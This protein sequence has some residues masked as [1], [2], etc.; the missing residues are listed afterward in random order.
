MG[1]LA[2]ATISGRT[3]DAHLFGVLLS[4]IT[5]STVFLVA[6]AFLAPTPAAAIT[7]TFLIG[8]SWFCTLP[9]LT[10][11]IFN[12][13]S[14]APTL[15]GRRHHIVLDQP[16][17]HGRPLAR[18]H[19][20][21][22]EPRL[23]GASLDRSSNDGPRPRP[24]SFTTSPQAGDPGSGRRASTHFRDALRLRAPGFDRVRI[25]DR[26]GLA[27]ALFDEAEVEQA[28][29]VAQ[30]ALTEATRVDTTLAVSRLNTLLGAARPYRTAAVEEL[31][32]RARYLATAQ[33]TT[34]A[35]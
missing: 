17:R 33:P 18:Q 25:M 15:P 19:H 5:A 27:P 3:A 4:G 29:A 6:L 23:H 14:T 7:L 2:G 24:A 32:T 26:I 8:C 10:T 35:S 28:T 30:Q 1:T 12:A 13:A 16:G 20:A 9:A 11:R 22:H 34:I 21:Q 31:R